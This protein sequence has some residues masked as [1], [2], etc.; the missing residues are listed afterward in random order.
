MLGLAAVLSLTLPVRAQDFQ[1]AEVA[2]LKASPQ[3]FWARGVVFRDT[4]KEAPA[5]RTLRID[6]RT[7]TRFFTADL[8]EAYATEEAVESLRAA[9]TGEA[10]LF[11]GTVSQRGRQFFYIIRSIEPVKKDVAT[12]VEQLEEIN[13]GITDNPYNRVFIALES[14]MADIQKDLF[15]YATAQKLE[16][17][18]LFD[19]AAGHMG[20]IQSSIHAALRRAEEKSRTPSQEYLVSMIVAMM[21]M[22]N[23]YVEPKPDS[24]VPDETAAE[25]APAVLEEAAPAV[26]EE[27]WDLIDQPLT[28]APAA[29]EPAM[30]TEAEAETEPAAETMEEAPAEASDDEGVASVEPAAEETT[31]EVPAEALTDEAADEPAAGVPAETPEV[32]VIGPDDPFWNDPPAPETPGET[33]AP[34]EPVTDEPTADEP[35]ADEMVTEAQ[36]PEA[37][38]MEEAAT[39]EPAVEKPVVETPVADEP[40]ADEAPAAPVAA[41]NGETSIPLDDPFWSD[42]ALVAPETLPAEPS[43]PA[44]E[45]ETVEPEPVPDFM[46]P[47]SIDDPPILPDTALIETEPAAPVAETPAAVEAVPAANG[48]SALNEPVPTGE[49]PKKPRKKKSK[50]AA[51]EETPPAPAIE[52][53]APAPDAPAPAEAPQ[54]AVDATPSAP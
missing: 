52:E 42:P 29:T 48:E 41:E 10:Y 39:E 18:D 9:T 26:S 40:V 32:E 34:A 22:Q 19:P 38:A 5:D 3:R 12:V 30:E 15:A 33:S 53:A 13:R 4:L 16:V 54:D 17:R 27:D 47:V 21:A 6:D 20:K 44:P 36:T 25:E 43:A 2:D 51:A 11:S 7:Y 37:P 35:V 14:I 46:K 1:P 45:P 49:K 8:G 50:K 24:F 23:G 31:E 28:D